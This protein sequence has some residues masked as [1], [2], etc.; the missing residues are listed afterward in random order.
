MNY[1]QSKL[2]I[3][4]LC[5]VVIL[6]ACSAHSPSEFSTSNKLKIG[7]I[8]PLTGSFSWLGQDQRNALTM[9]LEDYNNIQN[10]QPVELIIEDSQGDPKLAVSAAYKLLNQ[11]KV[12]GLIT[13]LSGISQVIKPITEQYQIP[14]FSI[15]IHPDITSNSQF[16][17]RIYPSVQQEAESMVKCLIDHNYTSPAILYIKTPESEL[18]A[19]HYLYERLAQLPINLVASENFSFQDTD[20]K[21][22]LLKIQQSQPD[23]LLISAFSNQHDLIFKNLS[24]LGMQGLPI[25]GDINFSFS[26]YETLSDRQLFFV[27]PDFLS[28]K[29]IYEEFKQNYQIQYQK[30]PSY[31]PAFMYDN[32]MILAQSLSQAQRENLT[33]VEIIKKQFTNYQGVSGKI[34]I[35]NNHD[36]NIS[37]SLFKVENGQLVPVK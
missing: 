24:E 27:A 17:F 31:D 10:H 16:V 2:L 37:M 6:S 9:A 13:S 32:F 25:L 15:S 26:D 18:L 7:A 33:P 12:D 34:E 1:H 29:A 23:I 35:L 3:I 20:L 22:Q 21:T 36:S 28:S 30:Q 5:L 8:I 4:T 14:H 19:N 11:G